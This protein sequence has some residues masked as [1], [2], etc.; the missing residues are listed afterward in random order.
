MGTAAAG[1]GSINSNSGNR[2]FYESFIR[3]THMDDNY[4]RRR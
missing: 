1:M 2:D 3:G 4:N